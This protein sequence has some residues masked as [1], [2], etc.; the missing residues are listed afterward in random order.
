MFRAALSL[1]S[2]ALL[3]NMGRLLTLHLKSAT[4][5]DEIGEFAEQQRYAC[6][7]GHRLHC[8]VDVGEQGTR[9]FSAQDEL[10]HPGPHQASR[11]GGK[12]LSLGPPAEFQFPCFLGWALRCPYTV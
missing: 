6:A 12:P 9:Q 2:V 7:L 3:D 11:V 10:P 5:Q 4:V 1:M 8:G